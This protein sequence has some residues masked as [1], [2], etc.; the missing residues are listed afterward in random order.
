[1]LGFSLTEQIIYGVAAIGFWLA[2]LIGDYFCLSG[3]ANLFGFF[4]GVPL[5]VENCQ[6]SSENVVF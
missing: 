4:L 2:A 6:R 1:M 5:V 3:N